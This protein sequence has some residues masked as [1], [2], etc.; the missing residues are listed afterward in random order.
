MIMSF[1]L[2]K[3]FVDVFAPQRGEIVTIMVDLPHEEHQDMQEWQE[4]RQ[5]AEEWHQEIVQFSRKYGLKVNP[6]VNYDATGVHNGI[7]PEFGI[8][9]GNRVR[10]DDFAR[11]STIIISMPQFSASAPLIAFTKKYENLR[12]ASLPTVTK[13]MQETGLSANYNL[14]AET[15]AQLAILFDQSNGIEVVFSTGHTCYFDKSDHKPA[16]QDDGRLHPNAGKAAFR[17]RNLPSGEV[18]ITPNESP[19]SKTR[20][21]IPVSY[22]GEL[23]VFVVQNNQIIDVLGDGPLAAQKREMFRNEKALRNIAEVAIGCNDKAVVTG[24]ILQ[25]EKAG[26]HWAYGRSDHLGGTIGPQDFSAPNKVTHQDIVYAKGNPIVCK[27]LDFV[28]PDGTKQTAIRDGVL[29]KYTQE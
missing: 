11:D 13:A 19:I 16:I 2:E 27:R 15:C 1:L 22:S 23:V 24:N 10:L 5:M 18:C 17:F 9:E 25:D 12:V 20:G 29:I 4:R 21:E 26:F 7:L 3:L 28:S 6:I 14:V 8:C